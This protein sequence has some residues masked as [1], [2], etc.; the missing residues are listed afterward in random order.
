MATNARKAS[1]TPISRRALVT[2]K[3]DMTTI[4]PAFVWQHE[5]PILEAIFG[6][7]NVNE[8]DPA[9]L[10]EGYKAKVSPDMLI[11]NKKQDQIKRPSEVSGI[12]YAFAG[13]PRAEYERLAISYG[14]H[15]EKKMPNVEYVYGRFQ[16]G[17]FAAIVGTAGHEDMPAAQLRE[18]VIGNGW[19]PQ[20]SK[21]STDA[22][23]RAATEARATLNAMARE[24]L[25]KLADELVA[26]YA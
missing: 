7:G 17:K 15:A 9:T 18:I 5:K 6:E 16:D 19:L 4:T 8:V 20:I 1:N 26:E 3:R 11:Y 13:D 2:V 24:D 22:E 12:G 23:K 21:E 25:I 10:D 14:M